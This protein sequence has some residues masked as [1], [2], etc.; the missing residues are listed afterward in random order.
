MINL[1]PT[2]GKLK[3]RV[4]RIVSDITGESAEQAEKRLEENQWEIKKAIR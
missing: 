2:N 3:Q 4:I 1:K